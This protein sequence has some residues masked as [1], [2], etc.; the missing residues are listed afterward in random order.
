MTRTLAEQ[1]NS[2]QSLANTLG[3]QVGL[4][5]ARFPI[6]VVESGGA[7]VLEQAI[8]EDVSWRQLLLGA[9]LMSLAAGVAAPAVIYSNPTGESMSRSFLSS[10][11][12]TDALQLHEEAL[13]IVSPLRRR[14]WALR[15]L[16]EDWDEDGAAGFNDETLTTAHQVLDRIA[17][18]TLGTRTEVR[19]QLV[20]MP[21]GTVI[22]RWINDDRELAIT[23][24]NMAVQV[25]RWTPLE[26]YEAE[27]HWETS[28]S[29][30]GE[31]LEWLTGLS[32]AST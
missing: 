28:G 3:S 22:F 11:Q 10:F 7:T 4:G 32:P 8:V 15:Q 29:E 12:I 24:D 31:H 14:L 20:P 6:A 16:E 23:V 1:A 17:L 9:A 21:D 19:P 30:I 27:G 5:D 18:L 25:Q 2:N 26:S 13:E